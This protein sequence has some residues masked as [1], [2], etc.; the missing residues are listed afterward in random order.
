MKRLA[1]VSSH[2]I[3][4][5]APLFKLLT[6]RKIIEIKVF[7]TWETQ[8]G[9]KY[10]P[11]FQKHVEWDI[12]LL[13]GYDNSFVKN[14]SADP[15]T[16][17]FNGIINPTLQTEIEEWHPNAILVMGWSFK[18]HLKSLRY[19][20]NK[21]PVLF[22]GDSTLLD[23]KGGI[24]KILRRLFLNW[25]YRHIDHSLYVGT[26]N[27]LYYLKHGLKESQL[28]FAPHAIDND[29]FNKD[30]D[31]YIIE[32][33]KWRIELS[34]GGEEL[35]FLFAGKLEPKKDPE[36]LIKAFIG[37]YEPGIHLVIVGNGVL[38]NKLKKSYADYPGIH[39]I[40]FQNQ[41]KMPVVYH[42]C[43]VFILPSKGPGETW[44]LSIN[45]AMACRKA[46]IVSN[47]AGA[48][49]DLVGN[50]TNGYIFGSGNPID[51]ADKMKM[52]IRDHKKS[53]QF[54]TASFDKIRA[55]NYTSVAEAIEKIVS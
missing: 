55:W 45:E 14:T 44:G 5:N 36:L 33:L 2:P 47:K 1:I 15:G 27:K 12:P 18:S 54:G 4:Y 39:F 8:K 34:I 9:G 35:V 51:L 7:Y 23:E 20:H 41:S 38:E 42:L 17:H 19:F 21:I 30:L 13:E 46:I 6:Q 31:K 29:R 37:I 28:T 53:K 3:Q 52:F 10:D 43:D 49:L 25:V 24:K 16:H 50:D 48:A 32:A 22:R 26:Q 40:D 11:G